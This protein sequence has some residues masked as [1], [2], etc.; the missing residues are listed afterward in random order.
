[1]ARFEKQIWSAMKY[2]QQALVLIILFASH[3]SYATSC[4]LE[5]LNN[6]R[7][8]IVRLHQERY[9]LI[10]EKAPRALISKLD[11]DI[12]ILENKLREQGQEMPK[13]EIIKAM[14][15]LNSNQA[16]KDT[17]RSEDKSQEQQVLKKNKLVSFDQPQKISANLGLVHKIIPDPANPDLVFVLAASSERINVFSIRQQKVIDTIFMPQGS[18]IFSMAMTLDGKYLAIG[19]STGEISIVELANKQTVRSW[20]ASANG[21]EGMSFAPNG[22][23]IVAAKDS[24]LQ[25]WDWQNVYPQETYSSSGFFSNHHKQGLR[26]VK[27]DLRQEFIFGFGLDG[28]VSVWDFKTGELVKTTQVTKDSAILDIQFIPNSTKI[29]ANILQGGAI[30][31]DWKSGTRLKLLGEGP[32]F[33]RG[34]N[35]SAEGHQIFYVFRERLMMYSLLTDTTVEVYRLNREEFSEGLLTADQQAFVG[36]TDRGDVVLFKE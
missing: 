9:R 27:M 2:T 26:G 16:K 18:R 25:S 30:L 6:E 36:F 11:A 31:V 29:V 34:L 19:L 13:E 33:Y 24:K 10:Q 14:Q 21:I 5:F 20:E 12:K 35:I 4:S 28:A 32:G 15:A 7:E 3:L 23:L 22:R 17:A 8:E 1:M